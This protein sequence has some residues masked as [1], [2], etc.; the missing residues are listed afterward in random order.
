MAPEVLEGAIILEDAFLRID[1]SRVR[2]GAVGS[3]YPVQD[4]GP[5]LVQAPLR[6]RGITTPTLEEISDLVV[7][8]KVRPEFRENWVKNDALNTLRNN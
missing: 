2:A 1:M 8:R 3:T 6:G 5:A 7:N 4:A